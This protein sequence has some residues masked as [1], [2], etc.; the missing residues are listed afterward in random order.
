VKRT[1]VSSS[2]IASFAYDKV[3]QVFEVEFQNGTVYRYFGVGLPE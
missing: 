3:T 2:L 1:K